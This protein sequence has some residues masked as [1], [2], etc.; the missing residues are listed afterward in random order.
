MSDTLLTNWERAKLAQAAPGDAGQGEL[1]RD[2]YSQ[3]DAADGEPVFRNL[4]GRQASPD[5]D[6]VQADGEE[7]L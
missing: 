3:H 2:N 4:I 7:S 1:F 6:C 5:D